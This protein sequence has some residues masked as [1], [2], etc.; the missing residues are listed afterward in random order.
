MRDQLLKKATQ[1]SRSLH[2]VKTVK[3]Q[4][5]AAGNNRWETFDLM[6]ACNSHVFIRIHF[7]QHKLAAIVLCQLFKQGGQYPA[8]AAP[9]GSNVKYYRHLM[10]TRKHPVVEV[11]LV[12]LKSE[13]HRFETGA[14]RKPVNPSFRQ[15]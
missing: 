7:G 6:P 12:D 8:R 14:I 2:A 15:G 13:F 3:N 9:V 5:T 10:R 1:K 11:G 4:P